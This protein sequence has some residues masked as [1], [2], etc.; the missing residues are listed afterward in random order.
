MTGWQRALHKSKDEARREQVYERMARTVEALSGW[1]VLPLSL[2]ALS[3][4]ALLI[5]QRLNVGSNDLK[6]AA[7]ALENQ[8]IVV[9]RNLRDFGRVSGLS[10]QDWTA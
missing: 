7:W 6:I 2:A 4:H 1:L 9:T 5:R 3:R 8:A 10:C